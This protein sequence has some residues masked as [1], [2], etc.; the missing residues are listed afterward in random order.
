[1]KNENYNLLKMLHNTLDD[2]WRIEKYYSKDA[3]KSK[4]KNCQA[5][6]RTMQKDIQKH[7]AELTRELGSHY[8]S[9]KL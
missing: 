6:Y 5:L 4:C 9:K 7:V 8:K 3:Q 1:M 2:L